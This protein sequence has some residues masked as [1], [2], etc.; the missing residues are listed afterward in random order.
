MRARKSEGAIAAVAAILLAVTLGPITIMSNAHDLFSFEETAR[1][2]LINLAV[3]AIAF[4]LGLLLFRSIVA[5]CLFGTGLLALWQFWF[6]A[7]KAAAAVS[8]RHAVLVAAL[9]CLAAAAIG[10]VII[11]RMGQRARAV[12][13]LVTAVVFVAMLAVPV[14]SLARTTLYL[15][16]KSDEDT[17]I[18]DN[19]AA[20]GQKPDIYHILLDGYAR[21]DVLHELFGVDNSPF[22]DALRSRGFKVAH[23]ATANFNQTILST[24]SLL[25]MNY[26]ESAFEDV[27]A[28]PKHL[29]SLVAHRLRSSATLNLLSRAGYRLDSTPTIYAPLSVNWGE[30]IARRPLCAVTFFE[31]GYFMKTPMHL[32]CKY[33][34]ENLG[35]YFRLSFAE[36]MTRGPVTNGPPVFQFRHVLSP[37]PPF[38]LNA[39]GDPVEPHGA[40]W[41][42][43]DGSGFIHGDPQ[44]R[45]EYRAGYA[46]QVQGLNHHV[47]R[48]VD[49]LLKSPRPTIIIMHGDHGS[50]LYH[51]QKRDSA[52]RTCIWE[53]FS[54]LLAVYAFDGRLQEAIP[55]DISLVNVYRTLFRVYFGA[56]FPPLENRHY[57]LAFDDMFSPELVSPTAAC[58]TEPHAVAGN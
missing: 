41:S 39:E 18:P 30:P 57:Y 52:E 19:L 58:K 26:L 50:G 31:D 49:N 47:L 11:G 48:L 21:A 1:P 14:V 12:T 3:G 40:G 7:E 17:P 37:H 23:G 8:T 55:E 27:D 56:A 43:S 5:A 20:I 22:L 44:L 16:Q 51:E 25:D 33:K 53:R 45:E 15:A 36:A 10:A 29:R 34:G 9:L 4:V 6:V 42:P 2:L 46:E 32:W 24:A 13:A 38:I 28:D 54:P 35:G